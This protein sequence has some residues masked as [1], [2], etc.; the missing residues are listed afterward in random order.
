MQ[1]IKQVDVIVMW[2]LVA[3]AH[4]MKQFQQYVEDTKETL[5]VTKPYA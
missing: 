3:R 2:I 4:T 1:T 5:C